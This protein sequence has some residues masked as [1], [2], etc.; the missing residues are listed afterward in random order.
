MLLDDLLEARVVELGELGQVVDIGDDVAQIFLEQVEVLVKGVVALRR[1]V[2]QLALGAS[3]SLVDLLVRGGDATDD[4]I[5][6]DADKGVD[7]V[8]LLLEL[9]D[10][11]LLRLFVPGVVDAEGRLKALVVDVV[12]E[13]FLVERLLELLAEPGAWVSLGAG[14]GWGGPGRRRTSWW[15]ASDEQLRGEEAKKMAALVQRPREKNKLS[16]GAPGRVVEQLRAISRCR[17]APVAK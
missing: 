16:T 10:K 12:E 3:D 6:L 5:A 11:V 9:L 13:P 2:L 8:E 17:P 7:L 14:G 4:L 15:A 1:V